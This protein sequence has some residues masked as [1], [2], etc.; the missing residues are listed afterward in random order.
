[1]SITKL[2]LVVFWVLLASNSLAQSLSPRVEELLGNMANGNAVYRSECEL[3]DLANSGDES[4]EIVVDRFRAEGIELCQEDLFGDLLGE[5]FR[6]LCNFNEE[7]R[8]YK[9][10]NP[11]EFEG[12]PEWMQL[13]DGLS[14][15]MCIFKPEPLFETSE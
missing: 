4:A 14:E 9:E 6:L 10:E 5:A 1:M 12:E 3:V 13:L 8:K 2:S 11:E 15:F 7:G